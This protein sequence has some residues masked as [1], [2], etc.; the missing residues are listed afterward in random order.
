MPSLTGA[1]NGTTVLIQLESSEG[2]ST[3]VDLIGEVSSDISEG[4]STIDIS[5]KASGGV[6]E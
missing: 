1:L 5:N 6:R 2:S 3:F 4:L